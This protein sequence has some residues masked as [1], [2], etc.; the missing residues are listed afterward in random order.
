MNRYFFLFLVLLM[1][2]GFRADE[3]ASPW[4]TRPELRVL[5][6][7]AFNTVEEYAEWSDDYIKSGH[8]PGVADWTVNRITEDLFIRLLSELGKSPNS[9]LQRKC[10]LLLGEKVPRAFDSIWGMG[11]LEFDGNLDKHV[12]H[13]VAEILRQKGHASLLGRAMGKD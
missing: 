7:I 9:D 6:E 11:F 1:G 13:E 4:T 8:S 10:L 5:G 3:V 2:E 12:S